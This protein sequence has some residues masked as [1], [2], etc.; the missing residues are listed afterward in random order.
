MNEQ[1]ANIKMV[2][3]LLF[4]LLALLDGVVCVAGFTALL[5]PRIGMNSVYIANV[6]NG[7]VVT[8]MFFGYAWLKNR[9]I[10]RNMEELMVIPENFG[11]PAGERMDLSVK[12]MEDVVTVSRRIQQFCQERGV[13]RRGACPAGLAMEEAAGNVV[14]H[15]FTKDRKTHTADLRVAHKD[16]DV[17]LRVKDDC[18]P[19]DPRERQRM[20]EPEDPTK[21]VGLRILFRTAKDVQYQNILGLNVLTIRI[22]GE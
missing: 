1:A 22:S 12:S 19:F 10:P 20:V 9:H 17:I 14:E 8:L 6:L 11:V 2:S 5:I 3:K 7:L 18:A 4:R 16:G 21:N 15:G 13:S